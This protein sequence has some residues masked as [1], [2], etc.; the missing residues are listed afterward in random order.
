[1]ATVP[2]ALPKPALDEGPHLSYAFQWLVF[3]ILGFVALAWAVRQEYRNLNADDPAERER[4]EARRARKL[5]RPS[6][7][8]VEDELVDRAEHVSGRPGS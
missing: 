6:D 4:A 1:M 3:A 5:A 7:A 8:Q 2:T